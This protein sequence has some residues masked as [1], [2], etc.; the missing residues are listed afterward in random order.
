ME[1]NV[2]F[3]QL[4]VT[5]RRAAFRTQKWSNSFDQSSLAPAL[6]P[7]STQRQRHHQPLSLGQYNPSLINLNC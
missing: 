7:G 3:Q 2:N 5:G 4:S 6:S 1:D